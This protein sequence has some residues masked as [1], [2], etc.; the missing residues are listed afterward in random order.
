MRRRLET[1]KMLDDITNGQSNWSHI[2]RII[3]GKCLK[4][5]DFSEEGNIRRPRS[6]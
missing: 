1:T 5:H 2:Y 6:R 4:S 3:G